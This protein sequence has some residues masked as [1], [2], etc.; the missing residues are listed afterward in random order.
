M[1]DGGDLARGQCDHFL[2]EPA[3]DDAVNVDQVT[4]EDCRYYGGVAAACAGASVTV[5]NW[6]AWRTTYCSAYDGLAW[7]TGADRL[8]L[9]SVGTGSSAAVHSGVPVPLP[10]ADPPLDAGP[11]VLA[12]T[13][14]VVPV[15]SVALALL[16]AIDVSGPPQLELANIKPSTTTTRF[17][18]P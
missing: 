2:L 4:G 1:G 18:I 3:E 12:T 11:S 9:V 8:L 15:P 16:L 6:D 7:P 13:P 10:S 5:E 17:A 14:S